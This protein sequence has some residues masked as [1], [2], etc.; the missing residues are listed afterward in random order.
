MYPY[1]FELLWRL[2]QGPLTAAELAEEMNRPMARRY[3]ETPL[4]VGTK[5]K[6]HVR[7]GFLSRDEHLIYR[8]TEKG[9]AYVER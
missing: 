9:R 1:E 3:N 7:R 4:T 8:I 2:A 6:G 5:L